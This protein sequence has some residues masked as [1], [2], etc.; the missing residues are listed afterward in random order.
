MDPGQSF[1]LLHRGAVDVLLCAA[2]DELRKN[3]SVMNPSFFCFC[4]DRSS[5][6][7]LDTQKDGKIIGWTGIKWQEQ[8][9]KHAC[10]T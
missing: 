3:S 9:K 1:L 6:L 10:G 8:R 5:L 4:T 7:Q 2:A